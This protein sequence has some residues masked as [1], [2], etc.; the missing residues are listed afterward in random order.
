M[1]K[2]RNNGELTNGA[3]PA[4]EVVNGEE[5]EMQINVYSA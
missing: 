3:A 2:K 1:V 5:T 4:G